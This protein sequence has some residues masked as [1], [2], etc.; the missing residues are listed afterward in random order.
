MC[1]LH[2]LPQKQTHVSIRIKR[3]INHPRP[4]KSPILPPCT[5]SCKVPQPAN[6][7]HLR[8]VSIDHM[9]LHVLDFLSYSIVRVNGQ[10]RC[11]FSGNLPLSFPTNNFR[12][13]S[14]PRSFPSA[15]DIWG[16]FQTQHNSHVVVHFSRGFRAAGITAAVSQWQLTASLIFCRYRRLGH[17][18]MA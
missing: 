9:Q 13:L 7:T 18:V 11:I 14:S 5:H 2:P 1:L 10:F 17:R 15:G 12:N 4:A 16:R 8:N 3:P 6:I